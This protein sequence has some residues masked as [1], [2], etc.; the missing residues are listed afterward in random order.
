VRRAV[1]RRQFIT[2]TS[3]GVA[4]GALGLPLLLEACAPAAPAPSG[5]SGTPTGSGA[6]R[7]GG[8]VPTYVPYPNKPTP[9]FPSQGDPYMDG[10][11]NFPKEPAKALPAEPPGAGGTVTAM[12]IGLFPPPTPFDANPAWQE[13]NRQLNVDFKM[14]IVAPADY[15]TKLATVMAGEDLPD[16]LFFYYQLQTAITAVPGAPQFLQAKA[17]DLTPYLGGDAIKDYPSLANIPTRAWTNSGSVYDGRVQMV[18]KPLY[19]EGFVLLK[20]ASMWE[21][22]IGKDV[23][24][25]NADDLKRM[26][27]AL[28]KPQENRYAMAT[29]AAASPSDAFGVITFSSI[30]GAPNNWRLESSGKLT[31][32]FET[33]EFKETVGFLR[34]LFAAG[35][36]HPDTL[37]ISSGPNARTDFAAGKWALWIDGFLTAWSDPWRR[38]LQ[39]SRPFDVLMIPPF[40]AH[41]GQ[42]PSHFTNAAHLGATMIKKAPPERVQELLRVLNWLAAPFGSQEDLLLSYGV[43]GADYNLDDKGNPVPT[44]RGNPDAN[45]LPFKYVAQRPPVVYLPDIPN[46]TPTM[47][48]AEKQLLPIGV[49][50]PTFGYVS[51]T[52]VR[53]GV[54]LNQAMRG[55][56][57]DVIAGRR[58]LGDY[59]QLVAEWRGGGGEQIRTELQ[60]AL[61][62]GK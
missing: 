33:A 34:D 6:A 10:Y 43:P 21:Q 3:R 8:L 19:T 5:P 61:A 32:D 42:K 59:D 23:H 2:R 14:N 30:F 37:Q 57:R 24:P 7:G 55:G 41:D 25:K 52:H 20:N 15:I 56:I 31:K 38:A 9:D 36:F 50:D 47:V 28:T 29:A 1:N 49:T 27:Q 45:Y 35:V 26:M 44:E 18:P 13:I 60:Q 12:T 48:A 39:S 4:L 62:A 11:L 16:L 22:D 53:Q 17:A 58:P 54:V 51:P 40:A 46:F